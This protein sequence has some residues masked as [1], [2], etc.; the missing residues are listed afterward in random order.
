MSEIKQFSA[1]FLQSSLLKK[2]LNVHVAEING[3]LLHILFPEIPR[4]IYSIFLNP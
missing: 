3:I 4:G 1:E 2:F